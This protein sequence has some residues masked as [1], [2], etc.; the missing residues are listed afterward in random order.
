MESLK[1]D[2][3][4]ITKQAQAYVCIFHDAW[5]MS[6]TI[7]WL[8]SLYIYTLIYTAVRFMFLVA[9]VIIFVLIVMVYIWNGTHRCLQKYN[10]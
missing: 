4:I 2:D 9:I 5:Y 8:Y 1:S 7:N 10:G 6:V 3:K